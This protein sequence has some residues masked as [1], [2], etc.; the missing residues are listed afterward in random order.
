MKCIKRNGNVE[1]FD[2]HD[3]L[4]LY[5]LTDQELG[6]Q[7]LKL[8]KELKDFAITNISIDPNKLRDITKRKEVFTEEVERIFAKEFKTQYAQSQ[9][10]GR[11]RELIIKLVV[12]DM[13]GYGVMD[14]LLSDGDLEEI[15]VIGSNLPVYVFHKKYGTCETNVMFNS[16]EDLINVAKKIGRDTLRRV[17]TNQ[18]ILDS[19]LPDGSRVNV[20]LPPV[21]LDGV[22]ITIRKFQKEPI[23]TIQLIEYETLNSE[24]AAFLWIA[25]DGLGMRPC[26]IVIAGGTA[27]GKTSLLD[28]LLVFVPKQE[29]VI[30]IEDTAELHLRHSNRVRLET[31]L[32]N[33]EGKGEVTMDDLLKNALRMRPDRI[34]VGEVRGSEA[35]TLFMAMNTGHD[36]CMGTIHAN[37]SK[38]VITRLVNPPMNV[39][40]NMIPVLD[41]VVMEEKIFTRKRG[42]LRRVTEVAEI[43]VGETDDMQINSL[44]KWS[45]NG[46]IIKGTGIPSRT[47]FRFEEYASMMGTDYKEELGR[48]R[49]FIDDLLTRGITDYQK[50]HSKVNEYRVEHS[51]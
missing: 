26:N 41:L 48:R 46:D 49:D 21:S 23:S 29:R 9:G 12:E 51:I 42:I 30:S 27:S 11:A 28:A 18:P 19:R 45:P 5:S 40:A 32:P 2:R 25:V 34:I 43:T 38:D 7:E 20:T 36:G 24:L 10:N 6:P 31:R 14:P 17:D 15:M 3:K 37:T 16:S 35:Q 1:I 4:P 33:L 22:S 47:Q 13:V 44:Y 50:I 8:K 39:P